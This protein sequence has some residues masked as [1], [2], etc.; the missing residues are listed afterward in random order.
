MA[1]AAMIAPLAELI[2]RAPWRE[3]VTYRQTRPHQHVLTNIDSQR[4]LLDVICAR[5]RA[6]EGV[7]CRFFSV[8]STY[9]FI[10]DYKY[11]WSTE[12]CRQVSISIV[13]SRFPMRSR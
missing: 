5:S 6:R 1:V 13:P 8:I 4:E 2:D 12:Q 9:L 3:A 11:C 10:G 7:T